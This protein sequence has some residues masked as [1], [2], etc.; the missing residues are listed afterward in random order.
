MTLRTTATCVIACICMVL[1]IMPVTSAGAGG[2]A[3][4]APDAQSLDRE[5]AAFETAK[6][7][8]TPDAWNA[9]LAAYPSGFYADM[10]RAYIK[11]AGGGDAK[12]AQPKTEPK[13]TPQ[14][15]P[16][17]AKAADDP[18]SAWQTKTV[19]AVPEKKKVVCAKNHALQK[20]KC[21]LVTSCGANAHRNDKGDCYCNQG[22]TMQNGVC[23]L[24]GSKQSAGAPPP[25]N[26]PACNFM[27]RQCR[28]GN[29]T[30]CARHREF[31]RAR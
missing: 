11:K 23:V 14:P 9:F 20:G 5:K 22:Y 7:L 6:E 25:S 29:N 21:V 10:A 15:A 4:P 12:A 19:E 18:Q 30:A 26:L 31:C 17:S 3:P 1:A 16:S 13:A 8:G 28:L 2:G 27:Q 24:A